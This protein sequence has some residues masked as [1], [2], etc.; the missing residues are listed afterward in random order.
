MSRLSASRSPGGWSCTAPAKTSSAAF[1]RSGARC[2]P[3]PMH[4]DSQGQS[5][6]APLTGLHADEAHVLIIHKLVEEAHGVGA[7]AHARH[8]DVGLAACGGRGGAKRDRA[9]W[10][11]RRQSQQKQ[12]ERLQA[13]RMLGLPPGRGQG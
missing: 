1:A 5:P 9:G 10:E 7:A 4:C 3:L 8:Q 13:S 12:A 11:Q 2:L 6:T